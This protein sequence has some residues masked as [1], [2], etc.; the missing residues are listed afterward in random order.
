MNPRVSV[1]VPMYNVEAYVGECI[2]SLLHQDFADFEV[3]CVDSGSHDATMQVA[4]AA[5]GGDARFTFIQGEDKGQSVARNRALECVRGDYLLNL[6]S[7]DYYLPQTIGSLVKRADNDNLDILFFSAET[8]Y[9]SAAIA[10]SNPEP[11]ANRPDVPGIMTGA[12]MYVA[13]EE[14]GAFRPSA[15]FY[16]MRRDLVEDAGL[17]F[18]E[19]II[20]EDLLFTMQLVPLASRCAFLN[21]CFYR[22]RMRAGS[23][24]TTTRGI[25]NIEGHLVASMRMEEW[26]SEHNADYDDAFCDAYAHRIHATWDLIA[27]DVRTVGKAEVEAFRASLSRKER[28]ALDLHGIEPARSLDELYGSTTWRVGHAITAVP[29]AIKDRV[30][31]RR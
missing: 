11:Q 20:H 26:L 21:E 5:A 29:G 7:D 15:C 13:M 28:I 23:T 1:I 22:R 6:D 25:R 30:R 18:V 31:S 14:S 4:Q 10:R 19:G 17:R 24:M 9:E 12:Q 8:F 3:I 27:H 2:Q 16:L